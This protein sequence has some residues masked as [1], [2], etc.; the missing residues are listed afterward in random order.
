MNSIEH[1][2][3]VLITPLKNEIKFLPELLRCVVNQ[4]IQPVLWIFVDDGSTDGSYE[5]LQEWAKKVFWIKIIR[6]EGKKKREIGFHYSKVVAE[7]FEYFRKIW[8]NSFD[9]IGILDADIVLPND[10]FERLI[11]KFEEDKHL[12]IAS[13]IVVCK[14]GKKTIWEKEPLEWPCGA[15]RLWTKECF[16][17]TGWRLTRAP[18]SVSTVRAM[19]LGYKTRNFQDLKITHLR[20]TWSGGGFWYGFIDIG[21]SRYYLGYDPIFIFFASFKY[22]FDYPH[23]GSVPFLIGYFGDLIRYKKRID[24]KIVINFFKKRLTSKITSRLRRLLRKKGC[25]S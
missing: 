6:L 24:D 10:Y 18:D 16:E 22:S 23:I 15:A 9:Y 20:P 12:G 5:L 7:G 4:T 13:G 1:R 3:Y 21:K 2:K 25:E 19:C 11:K 17:K 14:I 8:H